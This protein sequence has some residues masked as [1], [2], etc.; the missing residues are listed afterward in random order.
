MYIAAYGRCIVGGS[1][2]QIQFNSFLNSLQIICGPGL[3][4]ETVIFHPFFWFCFGL[5]VVYFFFFLQ[6]DFAIHFIGFFGGLG[7]WVFFSLCKLH[8]TPS[9]PSKS[10][11][12]P[13]SVGLSEQN[14]LFLLLRII[15]RTCF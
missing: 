4:T 15:L 2:M 12:Y 13:I 8:L 1:K 10:D 11:M 7:C 5:W 6:G 3:N 14:S 9:S